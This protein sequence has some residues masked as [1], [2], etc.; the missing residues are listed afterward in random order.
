[1]ATQSASGTLGQTE[2]Q[3]L[4]LEFSTLREEFDRISTTTEFNGK[5][6]IDGSLAASVQKSQQVAIQLG[7]DSSNENRIN[8]NQELDLISSSSA[9]LGLADLYITTAEDALIA[10]EQIENSFSVL[11]HSRGKMGALQNLLQRALGNLEV[12]IENLSTADSTIRDADLAEEIALLTRNQIISNA[13]VSM[14]GQTNL[15]GGNLL[16]LL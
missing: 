14:V 12:S 7:L 6:L 13:A 4:Q 1:L 16:N 15:S 8:L 3:T 9:G 10:A 2:R 11:T 5:N